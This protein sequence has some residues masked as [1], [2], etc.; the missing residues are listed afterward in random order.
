MALI[1]QDDFGRKLPLVLRY[2]LVTQ[3]I[4]TEFVLPENVK[5]INLRFETNSGYFSFDETD[6]GAVGTHRG[7]STGNQWLTIKLSTDGQATTRSIF[8]SSSVNNTVVQIL[9]EG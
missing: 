7:L 6:G 1:I 5:N 9:L 3:N 4:Y 8:L 2:T